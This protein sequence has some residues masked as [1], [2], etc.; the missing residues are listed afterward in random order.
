MYTN[1]GRFQERVVLRTNGPTRRQRRLRLPFFFEVQSRVSVRRTR[2]IRRLPSA[3][4]VRALSVSLRA[5]HRIGDNEDRGAPSSLQ[6]HF[7]NHRVV[8]NRT[9]SGDHDPRVTFEIPTVLRMSQRIQRPL[10]NG[11]SVLIYRPIRGQRFRASANFR[12]FN[13]H[14]FMASLY[15]VVSQRPIEANGIS[16]N[17][18]V[19]RIRR[20]AVVMAHH[21]TSYQRVDVPR[22]RC[23]TTSATRIANHVRRRVTRRVH[24]P[25]RLRRSHTHDNIRLRLIPCVQLSST[26]GR[27]QMG[28][29]V[30]KGATGVVFNYRF[31]VSSSA[32]D[33]LTFPI[34]RRRA[35]HFQFIRAKVL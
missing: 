6:F 15:N 24:V 9:P 23:L 16:H 7:T 26:K 22:L 32:R 10:L 27:Y 33:G 21:G 14:V 13:R 2:I 11:A 34:Y 17:E 19:T 1:G 25:S 4:T 5:V 30:V 8:M 29:S 35:K 20:Q 12:A 31:R 18:R 28:I 3:F